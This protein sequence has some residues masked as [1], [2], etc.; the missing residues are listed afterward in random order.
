MKQEIPPPALEPITSF[1]KKV[2][3]V[4]TFIWKPEATGFAA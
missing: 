3:N 4:V 1:N 2:V